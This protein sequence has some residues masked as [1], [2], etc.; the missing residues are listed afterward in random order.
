MADLL[1]RLEGM[2]WVLC[3]GVYKD[4]LILSVRSRSRRGGA[5]ELAQKIVGGQGSADGHGTMAGGQIPLAGQ[6]PA[7]L[8][9][10]LGHQA[11]EHLKVPPTTTGRP[12]I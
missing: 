2:Q 1:L 8:A 3:I 10:A 6:D 7:P 4:D 12:L 5:G 9:R 11:L